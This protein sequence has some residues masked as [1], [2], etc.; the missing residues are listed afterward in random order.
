MDLEN[1]RK[2]YRVS[3]VGIY[4]QNGSGKT[5]LIDALALDGG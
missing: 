5:S 3:I 1:K 2:D 4:G